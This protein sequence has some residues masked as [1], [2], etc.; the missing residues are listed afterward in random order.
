M[1]IKEIE[2]ATGLARANIR[3]YESEG[4][5]H[6]NRGSNGYRDYSQEDLDTLLKIKLLRQLRFSLE[7]IRA[8]QSGQLEL[9]PALAD[10][11]AALDREQTGLDRSIRLCQTMR[12]DRVQYATLDAP[13]YLD[14]LDQPLERSPWTE[15]RTPQPRFIWRRF[16]ARNLDILF[17]SLVYHGFL[18]AFFRANLATRTGGIAK[19]DNLF[20]LLIMMF[21]EALFLHFFGTTPGK[22]FFGLRLTRSDGSYL[23]YTVAFRRTGQVI[24]Y[25]LGLN[26]FSLVTTGCLA[27]SCWKAYHDQPLAWQ[28][29]T[30]ET[31]TEGSRPGKPYWDEWHNV[32]KLLGG[33]AAAL[34]LFLLLI[35]I[36]RFSSAPRYQNDDLTVE[37]FVS[38]YNQ[39]SK[40]LAGPDDRISELTVE[41]SFVT[42]PDPPN[43]VSIDLF[44][45]GPLQLD[46]TQEDGLLT[47]VFYSYRFT[48]T[49][50]HATSLPTQATAKIL[51]SFLYGRCGLSGSQ[52]TDL[53]EQIES[54]PS[55]PLSW[56]KGGAVIEYRP[57]IQ[58]YHTGSGYLFPMEGTPKRIQ[59]D[60]TVSLAKS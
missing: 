34:G 7:D 50:D 3:Y 48:G 57:D 42:P 8:L 29:D 35:P 16:F 33:G 10:Q 11:I 12:A 36:Q 32:L 24:V 25:G 58:G 2:S 56:N 52:L 13:F 18:M 45:S 40:Y 49:G 53:I 14:R 47:E 60:F 22:F 43:S 44:P 39:F 38:N 30:D 6:P 41:G 55:S 23:G 17:C 19:L 46:F 59:V 4:L 15:D 27:W 20:I 31:Y 5:I 51:W 54:D 21:S 37:Q 26:F 9:D 1:T 28:K